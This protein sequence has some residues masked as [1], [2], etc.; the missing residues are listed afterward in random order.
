MKISVITICRNLEQG[1]AR[2]IESVRAQDHAE[3]EHVIID[4]GSTDGTLAILDRYRDRFAVLVSEPDTGIYNAMNKG[5]ARAT[6]D[7]VHFLNGGDSLV[8]PSVLSQVAGFAAAHP[9]GQVFYGGLAVVGTDGTVTPHLPVEPDGALEDLVTGCLPHQGTFARPVVFRALGG[10][11]ETYRLHADHDWFVRVFSTP[12]VTCLRLPFLVARFELGGASGNIAQVH[13]ERCLIENGAP[14]YQTEAWRR[15]RL[16]I[17]Q[18]TILRLKLEV[19]A[20]KGQLAA[21]GAAPA[22]TGGRRTL[23][24]VL[25]RGAGWLRAGA[26]PAPVERGLAGVAHRLGYTLIRSAALA[27]QQTRSQA[28]LNEA[29]ARALAAEQRAAA[30]EGRPVAADGTHQG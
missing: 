29:L 25:A 30:A 26:A 24:R 4:G 16:E 23:G 18:D 28:R 12:G 5:L 6:G 9:E 27:E 13:R 15:R 20:L 3:I 17:H 19:A 14:V 22:E 21:A 11:D 2:T 8:G 7:L 10:F 1:I